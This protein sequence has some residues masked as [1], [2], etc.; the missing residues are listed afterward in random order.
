MV[1]RKIDFVLIEDEAE[2]NRVQEEGKYVGSVEENDHDFYRDDK[3]LVLLNCQGA[4]LRVVGASK[5][6]T[7]KGISRE[8]EKGCGPMS[9]EEWKAFCESCRSAG[10]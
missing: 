3:G 10:R 1:K 7:I 9:K 5:R 8:F 4:F 2:A 6:M